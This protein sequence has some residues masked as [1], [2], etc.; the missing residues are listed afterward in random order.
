MRKVKETSRETAY[1]NRKFKEE[2]AEELLGYRP[3]C[4]AVWRRYRKG[5]DYI[6]IGYKFY[7]TRREIMKWLE[8]N[9][10]KK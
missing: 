8:L 2:K 4:L 3:G 5:P 9:P 1:L 7:Y 10:K 6:K